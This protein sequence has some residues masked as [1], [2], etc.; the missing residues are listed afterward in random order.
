MFKNNHE[1]RISII[2]FISLVILMSSNSLVVAQD[3]FDLG[4][5]DDNES[6]EDE[7]LAPVP[8]GPGFV[9]LS[10]RAFTPVIGGANWNF[11]DGDLYPMTDS[12]TG[13]FIANISLPHGAIVSKFVLYYYDNSHDVDFTAH[14]W[15]S[16]HAGGMDEPM[17]SSNSWYEDGFGNLSDTSID[18]A[19]IDLQNYGYFVRVNFTSPYT[20]GQNLRLAGVRVDYSFPSYLPGVTK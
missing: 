4:N 1:K 7:A 2:L 12:S 18:Y 13:S 14:L 16:P 17:A 9:S 15:R 10:P 11:V 6:L 8:G 20:E 5:A 3:G 19:E